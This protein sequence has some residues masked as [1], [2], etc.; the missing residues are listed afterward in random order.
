MTARTRRH[1]DPI[2]AKFLR[3]GCFSVRIRISPFLF[4][5]LGVCSLSENDKLDQIGT[6]CP[7][8]PDTCNQKILPQHFF[9]HSFIDPTVDSASVTAP[10]ALPKAMAAICRDFHQQRGPWPRSLRPLSQPGSPK[11]C[12]A[13]CRAYCTPATNHQLE[14]L[15]LIGFGKTPPPATQV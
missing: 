1:F 15:V 14:H 6:N 4:C 2:E 9:L 7:L 13:N 11:K 10:G 5:S 3:A 12:L 8:V